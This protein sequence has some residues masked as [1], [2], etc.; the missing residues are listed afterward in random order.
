M[1]MQHHSTLMLDDVERSLISIEH[2]LQHHPTFLL[3]L[4]VNKNVAL[5]WPPCPTMLNARMPAKLTLRVSVAMAMI[6][7]FTVLA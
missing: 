2:S 3:F 4:G 6:H 7:C 5:V 1:W